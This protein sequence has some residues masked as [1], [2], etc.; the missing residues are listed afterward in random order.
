MEIKY[1]T[2]K[3]PVYQRCREVFGVDW[4][5]QKLVITYGDTI[6]CKNV[7]VSDDLV[8]HESTH[9]KQQL[10]MGKEIWWE[11]YFVDKDFRL[12]QEK[13]AYLNQWNYIKD[14]YN[15]KA[16]KHLQEHIIQSMVSIY[17]DMITQKEAEKLIR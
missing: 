16:R 2:G 5:K 6:Y 10:A 9:I 14:N 12:S 15:R 8:V 7:P 3:P 4:N 13:E 17:G 1:S 11:K